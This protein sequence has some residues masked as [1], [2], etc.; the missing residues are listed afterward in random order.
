MSTAS[1]R[2]RSWPICL[3]SVGEIRDR[4]QYDDRQGAWPRCADIDPAERG[5]EE[6]RNARRL[7]RRRRQWVRLGHS[8]TSAQCPVCRK[9]DTAQRF[10]IAGPVSLPNGRIPL[11]E[12]PCPGRQVGEGVSPTLDAQPL[13]IRPVRKLQY[14]CAG[15]V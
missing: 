9:A 3:A 6:Y 13:F 11:R 5:R 2:V 14:R 8:A 4:A 10:T 15:L 7:D 12:P 1:L